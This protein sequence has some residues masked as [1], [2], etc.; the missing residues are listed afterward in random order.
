MFSCER[1][2]LLIRLGLFKTDKKY[3]TQQFMST[4]RPETMKQ[5]TIF[6]VLIQQLVHKDKIDAL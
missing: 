4:F 6:L 5:L 3:K 1:H 2:I